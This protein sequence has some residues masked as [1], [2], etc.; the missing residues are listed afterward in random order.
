[1]NVIGL[2]LTI[3]RDRIISHVSHM[4]SYVQNTTFTSFMKYIILDGISQG[5]NP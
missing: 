1:M 4:V 5:K 2:I 3:Y